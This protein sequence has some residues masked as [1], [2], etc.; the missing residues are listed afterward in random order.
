MRDSEPRADP[1]IA[2]PDRAVAQEI[3]TAEAHS[4]TVG[5]DQTTAEPNMS[6]LKPEAWSYCE[7]VDWAVR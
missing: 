6:W 7:S 4:A 1:V 3:E 2:G 5:R